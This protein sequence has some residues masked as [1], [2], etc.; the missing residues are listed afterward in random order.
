VL[1]AILAVDVLVTSALPLALMLVASLALAWKASGRTTADE[2]TPVVRLT[3]PFSLQAALRFGLI[4]LLLQIACTLGQRAL[5]DPGFYLVSILAGLVSSASGVAAAATLATHGTVSVQVAGIGVV[6]NSLAS[7]AVKLPLVARISS[8]RSLT[9]RVA[10]ALAA[11]M[12]LGLVATLLPT[13]PLA[14]LASAH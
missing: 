8:D 13:E 1:L 10:A 14:S 4:F 2:G 7:T 6:L 5:G 9:L 12:L 11:V 3:S